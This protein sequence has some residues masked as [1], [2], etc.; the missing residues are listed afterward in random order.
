MNNSIIGSVR[1]LT[2]ANGTILVAFPGAAVLEDV[3]QTQKNLAELQPPANWIA[4]A[5]DV[6]QPCWEA[7]Q[8]LQNETSAGGYEELLESTNITLA[9]LN[10]RGEIAPEE[11][12]AYLAKVQAEL[13]APATNE[14][15]PPVDEKTVDQA[16]AL[17]AEKAAEVVEKAAEQGNEV[18]IQIQNLPTQQQELAMS[19]FAQL[20]TVAE[21]ASEMI[22]FLAA[23]DEGRAKL[24]RTLANMLKTS[25]TEIAQKLNLQTLPAGEVP[26]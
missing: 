7:L 18:A 12:Q 6:W 25:P 8:L 16:Q 23:Q 20:T 1:S 9:M 5:Q 3:V 10:N 4:P 11:V 13:A 24:M 21:A 19:A 14:V 22:S 26:A 15:A 17:P 2:T